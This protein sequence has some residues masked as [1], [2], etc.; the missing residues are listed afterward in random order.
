MQLEIIPDC[1]GGVGP[2][3]VAV[4]VVVVVVVGWEPPGGVNYLLI[5][6]GLIRKG[7]VGTLYSNTNIISQPER[8]ARRSNGGIPVVKVIEGDAVVAGDRS[9]AIGLL[10]KV[11][12]V[13]C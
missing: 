2:A 4:V 1:V 9:A 5:C 11:I 13:A 3:P 12:V 7:R 6:K 10:N 8:R